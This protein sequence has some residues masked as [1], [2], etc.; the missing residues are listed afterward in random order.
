[1][2]TSPRLKPLLCHVNLARGFRGGERQ[3]ELLV[4]GL[5]ANGIRQK[6]I[7][8]TGAPLAQ[9]LAGFPNL[10]LVEAGGLSG[11][12]LA[13]PRLLRGAALVHSHE[14]RGLHACAFYQVLYGVPYIATRRVFPAPSG[15]R[16]THSAYR[17]A[18]TV[19]AISAAVD[20]V[21]HDYDPRMRTR[22]IYDIPGRL[23]CDAGRVR[24]LKQAWPE[25]LLIGNVA[26][27]DASK[28]QVH[29]INVARRLQHSHPN[30]H[31]VLVGGGEN[32]EYC[33]GQARGLNNLSMTG[34][35]DNVGDYLAAFD[36]F[37]F[38]TYAEGLG[39]GLLDA[40]SFSLP[41][42]A[43]RVGGIPELVRHGDNGLLVGVADETALRDAI[44]SLAGDPVGRAAMGAAGKRFADGFTV[45]RMVGQYLE[46][47]ASVYPGF[48]KLEAQT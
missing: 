20:A 34:F 35:V 15:G 9:R 33:R 44:V 4:R 31:F 37:V 39:S 8:R 47:Y 38:P 32:E 7:V 27:L 25:K 13:T 30:L 42:I 5:A 2:S 1:M 23:P 41:L 46:L 28:G 16:R 18:A 40:M 36:L 45:D 11:G 21:L 24:Q 43:S 29:L 48:G 12:L 22:V 3:T 14:G 26:A 10:R 6:L 19:A 17:R